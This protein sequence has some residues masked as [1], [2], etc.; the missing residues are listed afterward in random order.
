M[1]LAL[2]DDYRLG[3]VDTVA[4]AITPVAIDTE[5]HDPDPFGAGWWVRLCRDLT[6]GAKLSVIGEPL[7]LA[8]VTLRA[9]VLN[10]GKV[11]AAASNYGGH[12]AEMRDKVLPRSG[13][14]GQ[15][16]LLDFDVF[17]KAPSSIVG[18]DDQIVLPRGVVAEGKQIHHEGELAIVIGRGGHRIAEEDAL[19]HV[20]GYLIGLDMTVRGNG[21]RSRR[22]SYPSFTPLGPWVTTLDDAGDWRE[23]SIEL[24]VNGEV[25]QQVS[26]ADMLVSVPGIIVYASKVMT[27][28]PGDVILTGAPP[29]V[30]PI[31]DGD[32]VHV[33][34]DRLGEL[35]LPV[36]T[37][38][39]A[40]N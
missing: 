29:G 11:I 14:T 40:G 9:P 19:G 2:Y 36:V 4:R 8:G 15:A 5:P 7:S 12:I 3:T 6:E 13:V 35:R 24:D 23:L 10:P 22:K 16:W 33:R 38:T 25:R 37:E 39:V 18:P 30:G 31:T 17:L 34:I 27:L 26:C 20:F 28:E 32:T 21:D 1:R